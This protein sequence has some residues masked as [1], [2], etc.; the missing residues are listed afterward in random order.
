MTEVHMKLEPDG[1]PKTTAE[2]V[3]YLRTMA[4]VDERGLRRLPN[5]LDDQVFDAAADLIEKLM[6]DTPSPP[7]MVGVCIPS[8]V[9]AIA[10]LCEETAMQSASGRSTEKRYSIYTAG[11]ADLVASNTHPGM[12]YAALIREKFA[13]QGAGS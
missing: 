11:Q 5:Y 9:E 1:M 8:L 10:K 13:R 7:K 6:T 2:L 12:G 4:C 3:D